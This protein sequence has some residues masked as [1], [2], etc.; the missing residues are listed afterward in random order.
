MAIFYQAKASGSIVQRTT[1]FELE[2]YGGASRRLI[3]VNM[4][5]CSVSED[6]IRRDTLVVVWARIVYSAPDPDGACHHLTRSSMVAR[7]LMVQEVWSTEGC[8]LEGRALLQ[9]RRSR[10][11]AQE[12]HQAVAEGSRGGRRS[13]SSQGI[14]CGSWQPVNNFSDFACVRSGLLEYKSVQCLRAHRR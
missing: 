7:A 10:R 4:Q 8:A 6:T 3:L 1:S 5:L 12:N 11:Q 14:R 9:A 13:C 2:P